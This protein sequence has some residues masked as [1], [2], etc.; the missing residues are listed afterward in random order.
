MLQLT[1]IEPVADRVIIKRDA[2][3]E[4]VNGVLMP[5]NM[6]NKKQTATVLKSG[7]LSSLHV[8]DR[9]YFLPASHLEVETDKGRLIIARELDILAQI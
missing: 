2:M 8:G 1:Q 4:K 7:P 9:V 3:P 6:K 5:V